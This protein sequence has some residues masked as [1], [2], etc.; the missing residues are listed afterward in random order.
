MRSLSMANE[1]AK[2][3]ADPMHINLAIIALQQGSPAQGDMGRTLGTS[4]PAS[5]F[6]SSF[7]FFAAIHF[8]ALA[9]PVSV[10]A[11]KL[12]TC[13]PRLVVP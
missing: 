11:S 1:R 8:S 10:T 7:R 5:H 6:K 9:F 2:L 4:T 3:K 13:I 12:W